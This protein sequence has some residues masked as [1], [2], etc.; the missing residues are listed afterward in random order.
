MCGITGI[1]YTDHFGNTTDIKKM[2]DAI[3]H[4]G[5]D[6]EGFLAINS[7]NKNIYAL[8]GKKTP[9]SLPDLFAFKEKANVYLAHRRLSIIDLSPLGH[10][11]MSN[12]DGSLWITFNGEIYN[13][14]SI[15]KEL[16]SC[17][18]EFRSNT[19]TEALLYAYEKWGEKCLSKLNGMFSFV[20]YDK[21]KNI[22]FGARDRF[23]VKPF[24]YYNFNGI[25]AFNSEIK[26]LLQI[27]EFSRKLNE[28]VALSY[29]TF[30]QQS[31]GEQ[32]FFQD[33]KELLPSHCFI[34]DLNKFSLSISSYYELMYNSEWE[35]FN[36]KKSLE[37][38]QNVKDLVLESVKS[39]LHADVSVGSCLSGGI[40][41]SSIVSAIRN[42]N[43]GNQSCVTAC[44]SGKSI[45]ESS[46]AGLVAE[47]CNAKWFKTFPSQKELLDD[48]DDLIWTQDIPFGSTS[49]YA[50]YRVMKTAKENGIT[51][52]LDGQGGDELFC[53]YSQYYYKY[54][55]NM[56]KSLDLRNLIESNKY[57]YNTPLM[58]SSIA[59]PLLKGVV[60]DLAHNISFLNKIFRKRMFDINGNYKKIRGH[61]I[62]K[63]YGKS[64]NEELK[65][66]IT[67]SSLPVLLRYEDKN[68]M[69]FSIES[70]TPF[71][72]DHKLIDYVFSI[73]G[74]YK[75]HNGW[76]KYL[77]R[78]SM[79]DIIPE[80]IK[81]RVDKIGFA[82]PE[83]E[84]ISNLKP[85]IF[86]S[87]NKE[88]EEYLNLSKLEKDW[89]HIISKDNKSGIT[90]IWRYANFI[91]WFRKFNVI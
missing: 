64:L 16:E 47:N 56:L 83:Y 24:Y 14:K 7:H 8:S 10:Q 20:I 45:D 63:E 76:S 62:Q 74:S 31:Y 30:G 29:L 84:W 75:I 3:A 41:S 44:Y 49:I 70:R 91:L 27:K 11:P 35:K 39:H 51:V 58:S 85:L 50:Q 65:Y 79:S 21:K 54:Y 77:L 28:D 73:P 6:G 25:F 86:S 33:V 15:K 36:E 34:Y 12:R 71:A 5:P 82:T 22:L 81:Y 80:K 53:G 42:L 43:G 4:R 67:Q 1:V 68:S 37:Y 48:L 2:S 26:G 52:M 9:V 46:W 32:T 17:G 59:G 13:Y 40:D 69:R 55:V 88:L 89:E 38:I 57:V 18:V 19:D 87:H 60:S 23:G 61:Y 66:E 90:K 72:D 78:E